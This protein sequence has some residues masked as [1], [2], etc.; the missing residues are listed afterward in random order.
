MF[1]DLKKVDRIK[2]AKKKPINEFM[3]KID[4]WATA[5]SGKTNFE[6]IKGNVF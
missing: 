2:I 3:A 5:K 4:L 1:G 6:I